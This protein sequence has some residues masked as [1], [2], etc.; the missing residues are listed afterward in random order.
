MWVYFPSPTLIIKLVPVHT[1]Y[2]FIY[3]RHH[4]WTGLVG[5]QETG[6]TS[7]TSARHVRAPKHPIFP[8]RRANKGVV[9][10]AIWP[11]VATQE[12]NII[13]PG[14][15]DQWLDFHE[16][17]VC[18]SQSHECKHWTTGNQSRIRSS[19]TNRR[20]S[21]HPELESLTT[22]KVYHTSL[23][24]FP[25]WKRFL[26]KVEI[27][28]LFLVRRQNWLTTGQGR[29]QQIQTCRHFGQSWGSGLR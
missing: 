9:I 14:T 5:T 10:G 24:S 28:W 3:S 7:Y 17:A 1:R 11:I 23:Q 2:W 29:Y 16:Y 25:K 13:S 27:F 18:F 26:V 12:G 19:R 8:L 15:G 21:T 20:Y 6:S 22:L 4:L